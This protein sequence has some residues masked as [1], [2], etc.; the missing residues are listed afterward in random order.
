MFF[1]Y[2]YNKAAKEEDEPIQEV[3]Y[4]TAEEILKNVDFVSFE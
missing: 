1:N 4:P 3:Y 2:D